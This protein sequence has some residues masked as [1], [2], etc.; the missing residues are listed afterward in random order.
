[1]AWLD[2]EDLPTRLAASG[3]LAMLMVS[4]HICQ[5]LSKLEMESHRP[6]LTLVELILP[7]VAQEYPEERLEDEN[8]E[9]ATG[10]DLGL[11]HHGMV[12]V[13]NIFA[14]LDVMEERK[15]MSQEEMV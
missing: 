8:E 10:A 11:V 9:V 12:C 3:A 5:S 14:N 4:L 1:M 7:E 6:L 2:V 15:V 13:Q